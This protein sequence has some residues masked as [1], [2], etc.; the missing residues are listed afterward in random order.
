MNKWHLKKKSA[1]MKTKN[2]KYIRL[3]DFFYL[4]ADRNQKQKAY[5]MTKN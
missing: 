1:K 3:A 4:V 5:S 2:V